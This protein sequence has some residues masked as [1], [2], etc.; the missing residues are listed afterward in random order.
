M[1]ELNKTIKFLIKQNSKYKLNRNLYVLQCTSTYPTLDQEANLNVINSISKIKNVTPGY[2]DHTIGNLALKIAY[3]MGAQVLEFHF[4]D[5][6][7]NKT[8]R[9]QNFKTKQRLL[10]RSAE[11]KSLY[12]ASRTTVVLV[13]NLSLFV[14][15][16]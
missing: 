9:D 6:R 10:V 15:L 2:S 7:K 11:F 5:T 8:F 1:E 4:T 3:S 14:L 12:S 13:V 16:R